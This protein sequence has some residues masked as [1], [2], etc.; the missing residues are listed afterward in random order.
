MTRP[1]P[2]R[3]WFRLGLALAGAWFLASAL[4]PAAA[5]ACTIGVARGRAT[6]D[7]RPLLWK[8][9][10]NPAVPDNEVY[11]ND[12]FPCRFTAVVT[13]DGV[14][15]SQ[16]WMGAN[17]HGF[18]LVNA[19]ADDLIDTVV[20]R[21]NGKFMRDA[22]GR[23]RSA[24]EFLAMLAATNG[25]RDTYAN[26]GVID[27]TGAALIIE[28][29]STTFWTY[30]A[31][32]AL[33][34]FLVRTNFACNDTAGTGIIGRAGAERFLRASALVGELA[35][36]RRLSAATLAARHARDF[37]NWASLPIPVPCGVVD[38]ADWPGWFDSLWSICSFANV[39]ACVIAGVS[40]PPVHEPAWL[41]TLWVHLGVPACTLASPYWPV[42]RAPAVADGPGTAPL[43]DV[44]NDLRARVFHD[45][46]NQRR[47]DTHQLDD[48]AGG[49]LWPLLL[50]AEQR[51]FVRV[52]EAMV[53]WRQEPPRW[54]AMLALEDS[55]ATVAHAVL[56]AA[57]PT[58]VAS[59]PAA[60]T[61]TCRPNPC[62]PATTLSFNLTRAGRVRLDVH[63]LAGRRVAHLLEDALAA[64]P[65]QVLWR[66]DGLPSG[67]YVARLATPE[68]VGVVRITLIR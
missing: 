68:Q 43:C 22:L 60:P 12:A 44:A 33:L 19:A 56:L 40:P 41:T 50:P 25:N 16:I 13:A 6:A 3:R 31:E 8:V 64:G 23:C 39:S 20:T 1:S 65:H 24:A 52:G 32:D 18:A 55:L 17:E 46:H 49:G 62:N 9:R 47:L 37:S 48:G 30:D 15:T 51:A 35:V 61:L 63:D 26:F 54:S 27:S 67:V 11:Y 29:S 59:A 28:A 38:D 2:S 10:D 53:G 21:A 57:W 45:P 34:G 42:G 14:P 58:A 5:G 4:T 66:A 36:T 7:G